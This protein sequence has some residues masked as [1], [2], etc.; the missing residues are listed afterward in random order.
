M[1]DSQI[2]CVKVVETTGE[3]GLGVVLGNSMGQI[4][5]AGFEIAAAIRNFTQVYAK[6]NGVE[7]E[8]LP[9]RSLVF[10]G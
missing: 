9:R 3:N 5:R 8:A 1:T 4:A 10:G 2:L 7:I 6:A